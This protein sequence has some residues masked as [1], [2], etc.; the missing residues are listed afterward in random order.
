MVPAY[1]NFLK[2]YPKVKEYIKLIRKKVRMQS[3][4]I[5]K[6]VPKECIW[7]DDVNFEDDPRQRFRF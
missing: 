7:F 4:K 6:I 1:L 5:Y 2:R 3:S